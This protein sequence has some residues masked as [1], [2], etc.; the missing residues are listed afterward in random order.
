[1]TD[2]LAR[3]GPCE[4]IAEAGVNHNG[5]L[6]TAKTLV[7][8]ASEAGADVVKFQT[9]R[10]EEVVTASTEKAAYQERA[11]SADQ[12]E[13]LARVTLSRGAHEELLAHCED[14]GV[15]FM[16]TPYEPESVELLESLGVA[17][18]KVASADIVNRPLLDALIETGK[19][20]ILSTGMATLGEIERAVEHL[21]E[22]GCPEV[23][24]LHCVSCYP[25][26]PEQVN[27]RFMETLAT[28][29]DVPV[30]YSDHTLGTTVPVMAA[31][32]GASVVEKHFT[33]DREMEGPDHF[34]SLEPDELGS[35]VDGIRTV[36]RAMGTTRR[37]LTEA[38]LENRRPMRRSLHVRRSMEAGETITAAD[39]K[40]VRPFDG[41]DPWSIDDV[42]G[43]EVRRDVD[44]DEPL[45]WAV[46]R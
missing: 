14:R 10:P 35:M 11:A 36:A 39:L 25:A 20:V 37:T 17:R 2:P 4:V 6:E 42:V 28:A 34:A 26:D 33:L 5:S 46:V 38:E 45:T 19:P 43:A 13:M 16:S 22:G 32:R 44:A 15:E 7:D 29:F 27:L 24:L 21:Q 8:R 1:M 41:I 40:V 30:G 23:T 18:Y 3:R 31:S 9:F 12:L